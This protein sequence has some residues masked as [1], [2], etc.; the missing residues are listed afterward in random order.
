MKIFKLAIL[1]LALGLV[2][3]QSWSQASPAA[4]AT[5]KIGEA[6]ITIKYNSPLVK[7]RQIWGGLVPY[8]KV[9]RAGANQ[10]TTLETDKDITIE[11]KSL[12]AG[13]YSLYAMVNENEWTIYL[14]SQTGQWG[15]TR[16]GETTK[17]AAK[18]VLSVTVK[19]V[20]SAAMNESLLYTVT[21]KGFSINWENLSVPVSVK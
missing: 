17:D 2:S 9:W 6:T 21:N 15:I 18:D 16:G 13:K 1:S 19:P 7:G 3:T 8:G 20:K 12:P 4:A 10:A 14:N 5:G 11:G